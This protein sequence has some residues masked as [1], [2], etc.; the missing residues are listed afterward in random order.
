MKRGFTLIELL[1]VVAVIGILIALLLPAVQ[2]ARS[3]ARRTQCL[4]NLKQIGLA[5]HNYHDTHLT[6]PPGAMLVGPSFGT[7]SGW[8]WG[9]MLLP[10]LDQQAMYEQIDFHIGTASGSNVPLIASVIPV[11]KCPA[12]IGP[13]T[14]EINVPGS[15]AFMVAHGNYA[16]SSD[17]MSALSNVQF[18][19]ILD[20]LSN[21]ALASERAWNPDSSSRSFTSAWPGIVSTDSNN[22]YDAI[23]FIEMLEDRPINFF[24]GGSD[25]FSSYHSGGAHM[26]LGDGS[27]R[28]FS[29]FMDGE[30]YEA[31]G[32]IA[33]GEKVS[34]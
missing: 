13:G 2:Q 5:A 12:D 23:P 10:W 29:E 16:A 19:D 30:V 14:L 1:V 34:F 28:F 27:V 21:T 25:C 32:T 33:G 8:G 11:W 18:N 17:V 26:T 3:S 9:A 7:A 6:L 20:G 31:L 4:N 22:V 24:V 15:G